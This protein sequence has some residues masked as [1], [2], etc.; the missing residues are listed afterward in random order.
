MQINVRENRRCIEEWTIQRHCQHWA[1][2][3]RDEDPPPPLPPP[4][5]C[6]EEWT[7]QRN[8]QH[9][10]HK[11]RDE[12]PPPPFPP[13]N[14]SIQEWKI[15]RHCQHWAHK[16][17]DEDTPPPPPQTHFLLLIGQMCANVTCAH[18]HPVP[19]GRSAISPEIFGFLHQ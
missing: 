6:I 13:P 14:R 17:R 7:I 9:W 10:A 16:T 18:T 5:R 4:N 3:T 12:D 2:K 15:Q 11:T 19:C 1:H 8:C